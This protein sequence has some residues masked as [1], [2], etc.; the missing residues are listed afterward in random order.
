M[1]QRRN[2]FAFQKKLKS[3]VGIGAWHEYDEFK[4]AQAREYE[5]IPVNPR[6]KAKWIASSTPL[7]K[8]K[9]A[10]ICT[11]IQKMGIG[12]VV[13][14]HI[15]AFL[16]CL[17]SSFTLFSQPIVAKFEALWR[18]LELC[19]ELGFVDVDLEGDAQTLINAINTIEEFWSCF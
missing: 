10:A 13:R 7:V 15:G 8:V 14:D 2:E 19:N 6:L 16:A 18:V 17:S 11:K 4:V 5:G 9:D 12:V 3:P 1:W